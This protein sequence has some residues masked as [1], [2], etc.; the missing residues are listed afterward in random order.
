MSCLVL[1][2]YHIGD[3]GVDRHGRYNYFRNEDE[4]SSSSD[5]SD[6]SAVFDLYDSD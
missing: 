3:H 6:N 4:A 2:D 5:D 1:G